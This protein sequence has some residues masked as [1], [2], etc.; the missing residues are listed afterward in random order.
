MIHTAPPRPS[1]ADNAPTQGDNS[2]GATQMSCSKVLDPA[3]FRA[4]F[5]LY[6]SRFL[7]EHYRNPE[8]VADAFGVRYQTALNWWQ[9]V[10]RPSGDVVARAFMEHPEIREHFK[11]AG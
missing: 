1:A 10:N 9:A 7:R 5:A 8:H 3:S 4:R 2:T 6:W 11:D